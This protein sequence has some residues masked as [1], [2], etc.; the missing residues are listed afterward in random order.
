MTKLNPNKETIRRICYIFKCEKCW[1]L[2]DADQPSLL[3]HL[4][5]EKVDD[6]KQELESW[7]GCTFSVYNSDSPK[8]NQEVI[9]LTGEQLL[10]ISKDKPLADIE[11]RRKHMHKKAD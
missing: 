10:P 11:R 4:D 1:L 5:T 2:S 9:K 7:S 8:A 3:V 6:F